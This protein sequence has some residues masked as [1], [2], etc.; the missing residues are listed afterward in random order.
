MQDLWT[1]L[2][3]LQPLSERQTR[4][5][6]L[7]HVGMNSLQ[8]AQET[9]DKSHYL[10]SGHAFVLAIR[11]IPNRPEAWL[12]LSYLLYLLK[13]EAC[14]LF[15]VRQVLE[16]AP[17]LLEAQELFDL[18]DSSFRLSQ[19]TQQVDAMK[20]ESRWEERPPE[21]LSDG[22]IHD[23]LHQSQA[24]LQIQ[25]LLLSFELD[26]GRFL[27]LEPLKQRQKSLEATHQHLRIRL[28]PF[29]HHPSWGCV[30]RQ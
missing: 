4:Y 19:L 10:Q 20:H 11:A 6:E 30:R 8:I 24:L 27:K 26:Q 14:A 1:R 15:Y 2:R 9:P 7:F 25:H 29:E 18:L 17:D 28:Q 5:G 16:Q 13:D 22:E 3:Q 21:K 23:L 12:G